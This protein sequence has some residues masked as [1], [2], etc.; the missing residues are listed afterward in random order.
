MHCAAGRGVTLERALFAAAPLLQQ[1]FAQRQAEFAFH[2]VRQAD[3]ARRLTGAQ[4][5][6]GVVQMAAQRIGIEPAAAE[7]LADRMRAGCRI[8]L[9]GD[10]KAAMVVHRRVGQHAKRSKLS[11]VQPGVDELGVAHVRRVG[12]HEQHGP[13]VGRAGRRRIVHREVGQVRCFRKFVNLAHFLPQA[14]GRRRVDQIAGNL[15]VAQ[16]SQQPGG[17]FGRALGVGAAEAAVGQRQQG[18]LVA[19]AVLGM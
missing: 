16:R 7:G 6:R 14:G 15:D 4:A 5:D 12:Q 19:D 13:N 2:P 17:D 11:K 8:A 9:G 10:R 1:T 3:A 18:L